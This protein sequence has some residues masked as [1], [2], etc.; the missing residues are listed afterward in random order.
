MGMCRRV[1]ELEIEQVGMRWTIIQ[2]EP[3]HEVP[4]NDVVIM[5]DRCR[6]SPVLHPNLQFKRAKGHVIHT[7]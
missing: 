4:V 5:L 7:V 3:V 1:F 2:I 6:D